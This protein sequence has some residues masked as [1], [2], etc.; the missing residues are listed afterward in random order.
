MPLTTSTINRSGIQS[1]RVH[2]VLSGRPAFTLVEILIVVVILGI[3]A[4]MVIV[5]VSN[6]RKDTEQTSFAA[7]GK[8]FLGAAILYFA[9]TGEFLEDGSSGELPAGFSDYIDENAWTRMTPIGGVWDTE[10]EDNGVTSALG[11]H[12]NGEGPTQD[13][14]YMAEIDS[15]V[16]DGDLASGS[17]RKLGDDRYYFVIRD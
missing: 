12:F 15:M 5:S 17:V 14:A 11:V 7:D 1:L 13:D 2:R 3:L 10:F 9:K 6:P 8:T 16:D 4:A